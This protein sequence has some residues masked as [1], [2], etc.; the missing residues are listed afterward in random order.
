MKAKIVVGLQFGDEGKGI[1]T[2]YLC[3]HHNP[4]NTCVVRFSGGQQAGHTVVKDG[5][6]HVFSSY[7]SGTL[8]HFPTYISPYC[9]FYPVNMYN[10]YKVLKDKGIRPYLFLHP[11]AMLTTP[12]DVMANRKLEKVNKHG[13]CGIGVGK[14]MQRNTT[15]YKV[16][17]VDLLYPEILKQKMHAIRHYYDDVIYAT[18]E[19]YEEEQA[20]EEATQ[21]LPWEI[22]S[23]D[24]LSHEF[25]NLIFEGSQGIMLD[26]DHGIFPNVTYANTTSKNAIEI[27]NRLDIKNIEVFYATRCYQT[28]HGNGW[29][30]NKN[31]ITLVNNEDETNVHNEWQKDFRVGE[32]DYNL[33]NFALNCDDAYAYGTK[34]NLVVTCLDQRPDFPFDYNKIDCNFAAIYNSYGPTAKDINLLKK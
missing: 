2:D 31:T 27:C 4:Q 33:L 24:L 18:K 12:Y 25:N 13:S 23:Y 22:A 19:L 5:I 29:M 8:R 10:E 6:R 20:F 15:P 32:L 34:R 14:T 21:A 16:Y 11:M 28:R 7:G 3:S 1:T 17:A 9:T 30:S 26:M